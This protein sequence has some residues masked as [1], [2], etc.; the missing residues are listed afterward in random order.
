M[1]ATASQLWVTT[2]DGTYEIDFVR[3]AINAYSHRPE[4]YLVDIGCDKLGDEVDA[5]LAADLLVGT[6][7]TIY[8]DAEIDE[9]H[10]R[11]FGRVGI[12]S[13]RFAEPHDVLAFIDYVT[14]IRGRRMEATNE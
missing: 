9:W 11:I 7:K 12:V 4:E 1:Y 13:E 5:A 3:G 10:G 2:S 8:G 14:D 6:V